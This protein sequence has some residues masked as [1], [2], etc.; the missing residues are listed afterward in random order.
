MRTLADA[1][2][3]NAHVTPS[4]PCLSDAEDGLSYAE[5]DAHVNRICQGLMDAGCEPGDTVAVC[6]HNS[7][8]YL[9][10]LHAASRIGLHLVTLNYWLRTPE[11]TRLLQHC[12]ASWL[13]TDSN[14]IGKFADAIDTL[15]DLDPRHVVVI[16]RDR[17][18]LDHDR[19][20]SEATEWSDLVDGASPTDPG[21]AVDDEAPLWT[22]YT[23]GT[24]GQPK[25]AVRSQRRVME[26]TVF[27]MVE[28]GFTPSDRFFAV[29]PFFHGVTFLPLM[30]LTRGGSVRVASK[31]NAEDAVRILHD[32]RITASFM[33]PTMVA[34]LLDLAEGRELQQ[35]DLRVL[36]TGGAPVPK[37]LKQRTGDM[38]GPVLHEFYGSTESGFVTVLHPHDESGDSSCGRAC[39]GAQVE[40][41]SEDGSVLPAGHVGEL[42]SCCDGSFDGYLHQPDETA[43][44]LQDGWF[45]A[46]D[47][48]YCDADGLVHLVDRKKDMIISGGENVY[49]RDVEDC[50]LSHPAVAE[51]AVVGTP[52]PV[53]G[54]AVQA[55]VVP[56]PDA[57]ATA[58]ELIEY[59][60]RHLA[61]FKRPRN[62]VFLDELPRNATG[63][64]VKNTLRTHQPA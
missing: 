52:D 37:P 35:L 47:L 57:V 18:S 1:L 62:V 56:S 31:F 34:A 33:V 51:C 16:G 4:A 8:E 23:S 48:A 38:L 21:V 25:G 58:D 2:S 41:R 59:C 10:L 27:G 12:Q 19:A 45:T 5:A 14:T 60:S 30:V 54:E 9:L 36:V 46:G 29:S 7:M 39:F 42:F 61:G 32:E 6:A 44:V 20:L 13:V 26:C 17:T 43:A 63:K 3:R 28:F 15:P 49:P 53:W 64:V 55:F 24:T 40:V 50:L 22:M 11:L